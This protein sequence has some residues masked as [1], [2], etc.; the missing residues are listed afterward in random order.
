MA[1]N[2]NE[3]MLKLKTK[4][5]TKDYLPVQFRLVWF[6]DLCPNGTID[7]EEIVV[8]LDREITIETSSW[9]QETRKSEKVMKVAKGYARYKAIVTDGQGGRAVGHNSDS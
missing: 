5:G 4:D 3:H 1:F 8:D 7:T 6:R 2:P 9:N